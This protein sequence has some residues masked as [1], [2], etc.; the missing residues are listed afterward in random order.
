MIPILR[1]ILRT[2]GVSEPAYLAAVE[3]MRRVERL[4]QFERLVEPLPRR[5][6]PLNWPA[7][8]LIVAIAAAVLSL[9]SCLGWF[10]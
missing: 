10:Q 2:G 4:N 6:K 7:I 3:D 9:P 5:R 1:Q 8:G